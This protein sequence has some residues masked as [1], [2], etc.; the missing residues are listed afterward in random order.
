VTTGRLR[1]LV[2]HQ[3]TA[4]MLSQGS[5]GSQHHSSSLLHAEGACLGTRR[6]GVASARR[7]ISSRSGDGEGVVRGTSGVHGVGVVGIAGE[8]RRIGIA[9]FGFVGYMPT[10]F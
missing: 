6:V 1:R 7:A 8:G 9:V 2:R 5:Q 4:V 3:W 10:S